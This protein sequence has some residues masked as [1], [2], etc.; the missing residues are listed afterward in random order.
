M[1]R[2]ARL[3]EDLCEKAR[4]DRIDGA[5][6]RHAKRDRLVVRH[7]REEIYA[8]VVDVRR[9]GE[10]HF[11]QAWARV[12]QRVYL[13]REP[14][15]QPRL[16]LGVVGLDVAGHDADRRT[17]IDLLQP[18]ED[19]SKERLVL[20]RASEVGFTAHVVDREDDDGIHAR[21]THPLRREESRRGGAW[22]E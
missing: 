19:R 7:A 22:P 16:K 8:A 4:T 5:A 3:V 9:F 17:P 12:R 18:L 10:R 6:A 13:E 21:F 1:A 2:I 20:R 15:A 11:S 14:F